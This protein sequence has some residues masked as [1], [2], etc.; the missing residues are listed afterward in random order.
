MS[1]VI[2]VSRLT[3]KEAADLANQEK[4]TL[5]LL[6]NEAIRQH[7]L[8]FVDK[9]REGR[10]L[11]DQEL[12]AYPVRKA[13]IGWRTTLKVD[14]TDYPLDVMVDSYFPFSPPR[15]ALVDRSKFLVW[16]HVEHDGCL[17]L[18]DSH[19]QTIIS[20]EPVL[21]EHLLKEE[22]TQLIRLC[23]TGANRNDFISEFHS[24]WRTKKGSLRTPVWSLMPPDQT[25]RTG[26][27]WHGK[28]FILAGKNKEQ[29]QRWL[30]N[31][32]SVTDGFD[33]GFSDV[34][35]LWLASP[36]FPDQ[37]PQSNADFARLIKRE[38]E[39]TYEFL[40]KSFPT[41]KSNCLVLFGFD[42]GDGNTTAGVWLRK[43]SGKMHNGFRP[44]HIPKSAMLL[45]YMDNYHSLKT[46]NVKRVDHEWIHSRGGNLD[47]NPLRDKAVAIVG[48]GSVGSFVAQI[49]TKAGVGRFLFIDADMLSWDNVAR[50]ALGGKFVNK[51]KS[52]GMLKYFSENY[53]HLEF[54]AKKAC[55]EDCFSNDPELFAGYDVIVS[56]IGDWQPEALLNYTQRTTPS[57]PTVVYGWTEAF[58]CAGHALV[59]KE[60]GGCLA[61]GMNTLGG[62]QNAATSWPHG[63]TMKKIPACGGFYQPYG[64]TDLMPIVSMVSGLV[65]K[66]MLGEIDRSKHSLWIGPL[67]HL[68]NYGGSLTTLW[69]EAYED[70]IAKNISENWPINSGCSLCK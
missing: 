45:R 33:E 30:S 13:K 58:A 39:E 5:S 3:K 69:A 56:T 49:L 43:P 9:K 17:C 53:P 55:W 66:E 14:G 42:S 24:Y 36:L 32:Y 51:Y 16:P 54:Q 47:L 44:K 6:F 18:L 41:T 50:H 60:L 67:E 59:V 28:N 64:I 23:R 7:D 40:L 38:G 34:I 52:E 57:F 22:I 10:R 62:F 2:Q 25:H 29:L 65:I 61:C 15:I 11:T 1:G 46:V 26:V 21:V 63:P 20:P 70:G 4:A 27:C 19:T 37:Y 8:Y 35:Y 48:C 12:S 31:Y 68:K